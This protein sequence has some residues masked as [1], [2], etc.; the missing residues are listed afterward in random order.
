MLVP[1]LNRHRNY[2]TFFCIE[3]ELLALSFRSGLGSLER[4]S[5]GALQKDKKKKKKKNGR[6][7]SVG[8]S[9]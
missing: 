2:S 6:K 7:N 3:K 5:F 1:K 4:S 8:M 9:E